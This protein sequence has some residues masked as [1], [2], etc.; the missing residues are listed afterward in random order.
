MDEPLGVNPFEDEAGAS[1]A[2]QFLP[3]RVVPDLLSWCQELQT[4]LRQRGLPHPLQVEDVWRVVQPMGEV[5]LS[6]TQRSAV[7]AALRQAEP[8]ERLKDAWGLNIP[9]LDVRRPVL[10]LESF[11]FER[12]DF[13]LGCSKWQA[14]R[15]L[16]AFIYAAQVRPDLLPFSVAL[17]KHKAQLHMQRCAEAELGVVKRMEAYLAR[18]GESATSL[19]AALDEQTATMH[20]LDEQKV[21]DQLR[22]SIQNKHNNLLAAFELISKF[23]SKTRQLMIASLNAVRALTPAPRSPQ[24][25][26]NRR[27][28]L[29][30]DGGGLLASS[31]KLRPVIGEPGTGQGGEGEAF[32]R[33]AAVSAAEQSA[34]EQREDDAVSCAPTPMLERPRVMDL[35]GTGGDGGGVA[36]S[37]GDVT[38]PEVLEWAKQHVLPLIQKLATRQV[39]CISGY[40]GATN[41]PDGRWD[42]SDHQHRSEMHVLVQVES[43][44]RGRAWAF[45]R[46]LEVAVIML[47]KA[48]LGDRAAD[49]VVES[50]GLRREHKSF[51]IYLA[52]QMAARP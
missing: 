33:Q 38:F 11:T 28:F 29:D 51:S 47:V 34:A 36:A 43:D 1:Q 15:Y 30:L 5:P 12:V 18:H 42:G 26:T 14:M 45:A 24:P 2:P 46:L 27:I 49:Q 41:S 21:L 3:G 32:R 23:Y 37:G 35:F 13:K 9:E 52:L 7:L 22:E 31:F 4:W 48:E 6:V 39:L 16:L 50:V 44:K 8:D 10:P 40:G 17:G 19:F 20:A 25:Y